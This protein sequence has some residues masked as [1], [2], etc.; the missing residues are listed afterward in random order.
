MISNGLN[1]SLSEKL[2]KIA[3]SDH[4]SHAYLF[5]GEDTGKGFEI[6][7]QFAGMITDSQADILIL[8]HEKPNLISVDDIRTGINETVYIKPYA[9]EKKIYIVPDAQK[10]NVQAQNALLKTLEEP[11]AYVVILL[12]ADSAEGF[13]QTILSRVVKLTVSSEEEITADEDRQAALETARLIVRDAASMDTKKMLD[14]VAQ[15]SEKKLYIKEILERLRAWLRDIRMWQMTQD[16]TLLMFHKDA[17]IVR[18][19]AEKTRPA[20]ITRITEAIDAA[21]RRLDANVNFEVTAE[22]LLQT[23]R[24]SLRKN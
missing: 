6:A 10:M 19:F 21:Q 14:T 15:L 11:P 13:L 18:Q 22:L 2:K 5:G 9:G 16:P 3:L 1:D 24:E 8:E 17:A 4:V 7:R 23:M 12:V 20:D